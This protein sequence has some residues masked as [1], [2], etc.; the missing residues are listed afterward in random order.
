MHSA[1][2]KL[3]AREALRGKWKLAVCVGLVA[4]LLGAS[5]ATSFE[6]TSNL[7]FSDSG[8]KINPDAVGAEFVKILAIILL[9]AAPFML[10]MTCL[11]FSLGC[12]IDIGYSRFNLRLIDNEE[13]SFNDLFAYFPKWKTAVVAGLLKFVYI[14]LWSLLFIVPGVIASLNYAMTSFIIA[15]NDGISAGEALEESKELMYGNRWK[16]FCL[17]F[18]FIGWD[19]LNLF[20]FGLGS[21]WLIPYKS[22]AIADFYREISKT[23]KIEEPIA[24]ES[25]SFDDTQI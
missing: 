10:A 21:L 1:D 24:E 22:A 25:A 12:I 9:A 14:F 5:T 11:S 16:L 15:E 8:I 23:R 19:I 4:S 2:F 7:D 17:H 13:S 3:R 18:S 20:S 6:F